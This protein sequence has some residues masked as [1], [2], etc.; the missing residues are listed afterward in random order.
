MRSISGNS[1]RGNGSGRRPDDEFGGQHHVPLPR[2]LR[3]VEEQLAGDTALAAAGLAYRGQPGRPGLGDVVEPGDR[4]VATRPQP[5]GR[6]RVE[7]AERE[8]VATGE[9]RGRPVG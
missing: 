5:P 8:H 2:V 6:E 4:Y 1:L 7:D 3:R 9:Y